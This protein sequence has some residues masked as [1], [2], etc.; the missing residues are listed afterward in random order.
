MQPARQANAR[1]AG[2]HRH[3]LGRRAGRVLLE[4]DLT[5]GPMNS[6]A[7]S[8]PSFSPAVER[9]A[10][11]RGLVETLI[12]PSASCS[13]RVIWAP[14]GY[15]HRVRSGAP[16]AAK[17][18]QPRPLPEA[19]PAR[20]SGLSHSGTGL[21][22]WAQEV[23]VRR[24]RCRWFEPQRRGGLG[25]FETPYLLSRAPGGVTPPAHGAPGSGI[26]DRAAQNVRTQLA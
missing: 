9:A 16:P 11:K 22:G 12:M 6:R 24:R 20:R 18:G 26:G 4:V 3:R 19:A 15:P 8:P 1:A 17:W 25:R 2:R 7:K 14:G 21:G 10:E 5:W 23:A 13:E